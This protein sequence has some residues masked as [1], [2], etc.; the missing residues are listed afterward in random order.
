MLTDWQSTGEY[1]TQAAARVLRT[2]AL[3]GGYRYIE[4]QRAAGL[5]K[6]RLRGVP[7]KEHGWIWDLESER[8]HYTGW[9]DGRSVSGR[10]HA[11]A[12]FF[13][14]FSHV[15]LLARFAH[16]PDEFRS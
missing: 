9:N 8:I 1:F 2:K 5:V 12:D 3:L 6:A 14:L 11:L 10:R 15:A 7:A 13:P 16:T 4:F